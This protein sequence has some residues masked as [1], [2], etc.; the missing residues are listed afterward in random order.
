MIRPVNL[1]W[2]YTATVK[3]LHRIH[4]AH[5]LRPHLRGWRAVNDN[6]GVL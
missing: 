6:G 1:A 3:T 4:E 2:L 5:D